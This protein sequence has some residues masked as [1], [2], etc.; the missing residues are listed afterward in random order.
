M[1]AGSIRPGD[2][3]CRIGGEEF[4]VLLPETALDGA[5]RLAD[6]LRTRLGSVEM[7]HE[8]SPV[9]ITAS[10]G[11]TSTSLFRGKWCTGETMMAAADEALYE[12]KQAGR[13]CIKI[14][15]AA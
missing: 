10:F 3:A 1:L 7:E 4:A 11:V 8:G 5:R 13:D 15:T 6:E 2:I 12:A 14:K 9:R